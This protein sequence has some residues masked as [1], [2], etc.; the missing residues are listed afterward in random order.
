MFINN[1]SSILEPRWIAE[2]RTVVGNGLIP[3]YEDLNTNLTQSQSIGVGL[4]WYWRT[5]SNGHRYI[6]HEGSMPGVANSILVNERN[7][8]GVIILSNGDIT[9]P[10]DRSQKISKTLLNIQMSLFQCFDTDTASGFASRVCQ[11]NIF[12]L[13]LYCIMSILLS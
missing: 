10:N 11:N 3:F 7:S 2:I 6:G 9:P 5:M 4:G 13:L 1:G 8:I 12:V